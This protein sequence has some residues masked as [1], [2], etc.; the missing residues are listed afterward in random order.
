MLNSTE[1]ARPL[2]VDLDGTLIKSDV[3]FEAIILLIKKNIFFIFAMLY[4]F[5]KAG[6]PYFKRQIAL[7]VQPDPR[8]LPYNQSLL[9]Y[10]HKQRDQGRKLVLATAADEILAKKVAAHLGI[11]SEIVAS[12]GKQSLAG[13]KKAKALCDKYGVKG[14]D[15]A[16]D[17]YVDLPVWKAANAIIIVTNSHLL[18]HAANR[19][20]PIAFHCAGNLTLQQVWLSALRSYQWT[21]NLLVFLPLLI[22]YQ[23]NKFTIIHVSLAFICFCAAASAIYLIN[24]LLDLEEDRSHPNKPQRPLASGDLWIKL[25]CLLIPIL[26]SF[27]FGVAI[28]LPTLFKKILLSYVLLTIFYSLYFKHLLAADVIILALLYTIRVIAGGTAAYIPISVWL[29]AWVFFLFLSLALMKRVS[30]LVLSQQNSSELRLYQPA[31]LE[32][33]ASAGITSGYLTVLIFALYSNSHAILVLHRHPGWLWLSCPLLLYWLQR[34]WLLARRGELAFDPV[35]FALRDKI[36]YIIA[37]LLLTILVIS[38]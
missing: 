8:Y 3:L 20:G 5:I 18:L 23:I 30:I 37:G 22:S 25:C 34:A 35:L 10:L 12:D 27:S 11:F 28:V 17:S 9:S 7:R 38:H 14:F 4:W 32:S 29:L 21:K 33:L 31:D 1:I 6:K 26:L 19:I 16:G 13:E 2:C 15:Y 36:S 24:D